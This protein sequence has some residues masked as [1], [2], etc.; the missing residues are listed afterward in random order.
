MHD[1]EAW[2]SSKDYSTGVMLYSKYGKYKRVL[3]LLQKGE[4]EL[5]RGKLLDCLNRLRGTVQEEIKA[6]TEAIKGVPLPYTSATAQI[7]VAVNADDPVILALDKKWKP[8][9]GE[10]AMLH[11]RLLAVDSKDARYS[12]AVRISDLHAEIVTYWEQI[13]H[14]RKHGKLPDKVVRKKVKEGIT[15]TDLRKLTTNRTALSHYT[16][17]RLPAAQARL[18]TEPNAKNKKN[19]ERTEAAIEKYKKIIAELENPKEECRY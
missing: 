12:L 4:T 13:A 19:L 8:L 1:L 7:N 16:R 3:F 14:Y 15:Q 10:M 5:N 18:A 9:Y 6:R 11:S 17:H 2:F